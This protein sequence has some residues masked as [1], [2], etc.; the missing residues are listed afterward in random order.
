[1]TKPP[2]HNNKKRKDFGTKIKPG[3]LYPTAEIKKQE[4]RY[5]EETNP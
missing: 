5:A 3:K 2:K 4:A 1:M